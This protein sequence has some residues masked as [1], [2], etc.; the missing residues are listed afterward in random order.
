MWAFKVFVVVSLLSLLTL[1]SS[2]YILSTTTETK[3]RAETLEERLE[4]T[5]P[6]CGYEVSI[7][8][9]SI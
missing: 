1:R 4:E 8:G 3:S 5:P 7:L 9:I 2:G 6:T